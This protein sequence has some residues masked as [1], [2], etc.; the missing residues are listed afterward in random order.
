MKKVT[1]EIQFEREKT[2]PERE[3]IK[4]LISQL[5]EID[6]EK[7]K[8][9]FISTHNEVIF[10]QLKSSQIK[11]GM[12]SLK[13]GAGELLTEQRDILKEPANYYTNLYTTNDNPDKNEQ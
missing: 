13:N 10:K 1:E 5:K 8:K 2:Q 7:K 9:I 6:L 12:S 3:I 11:H 4:T